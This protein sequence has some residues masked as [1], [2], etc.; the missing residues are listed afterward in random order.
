MAMSRTSNS[1]ERHENVPAALGLIGTEPATIKRPS[2][3]SSIQRRSR[4]SRD[5]KALR[6][7]PKP[8]V[9]TPKAPGS[10]S[11]FDQKVDQ[12]NRLRNITP[13]QSR[14]VLPLRKIKSAHAAASGS[15]IFERDTLKQLW[16]STKGGWS[17]G[18]M[19]WRASFDSVGLHQWRSAPFGLFLNAKGR[20]IK[21]QLASNGLRGC[22]PPSFECFTLLQYIYLQNNSLSGPIPSV[23]GL[24]HL[25]NFLINE[26]Q[27][28]GR[29]PACICSL[30]QLEYLIFSRNSITGEIPKDISSCSQLK[31]LAANH[32]QLSG[33]IPEGISACYTLTQ[34]DLASND[35]G[36]DIPK[37]LCLLTMLQRLYLNDNQLSGQLPA[38]GLENLKNLLV[39]DCARNKLSGEIPLQSLATLTNLK[40]I[41]C[42]GNTFEIRN[43]TEAQ[44]VEDGIDD[45]AHC[46][47]KSILSTVTTI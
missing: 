8:S 16:Q 38:K 13:A 30:P 14:A 39:F 28:S 31:A 1:H 3:A 27:L 26:N 42:S 17:K 29:I 4:T 21:L 11:V 9:K 22:L 25:K 36:G 24:H 46:M 15:I 6:S 44:F 7:Q 2:T 34:L 5:S 20:L 12:G 40:S 23:S 18:D 10:K 32:N 35:I 41:K 47:I 19:S 43:K 33:C 37:S 45:N